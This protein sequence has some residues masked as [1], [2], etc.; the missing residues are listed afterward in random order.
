MDK[1]AAQVSFVQVAAE[2]ALTRWGNAVGVGAAPFLV[3]WTPNGQY[4]LVNPAEGGADFTLRGLV[5]SIRVAAG[6]DAKGAPE[7]KV[8]ARAETGVIPEG[9]AI[10][11]DGRWVATSNLERSWVPQ[12]VPNRS[13]FSSITLLR[14]N[15]D[16][17][18][19]RMGDFALDGILPE[20]VL[21]DNSSQF[22]A[23]HD[24]RPLRRPGARR[25]AQLLA[26][27]AG[28]VRS[29][30]RP[31]GQKQSVHSGRA[32]RAHHG[33]RP[34]EGRKNWGHNT[35]FDAANKCCSH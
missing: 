27:R 18:L 21:F 9:L 11:P 16:G 6:R 1:T 29:A 10:S 28:H 8:V 32:R 20:T 26:H 5:M 7:H 30:A 13:F 25:L 15:P 33:Y 19:E 14:L 24:L 22:L 35:H 34:I 12:G 23:S 17:T 3:R 4:V 31:T 2:G